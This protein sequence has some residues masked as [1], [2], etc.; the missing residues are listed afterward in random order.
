MTDT[1]EALAELDAP[2]A[3]AGQAQRLPSPKLKAPT[4]RPAHAGHPDRYP[5]RQVTALSGGK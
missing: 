2:I 4:E 3:P 1:V 5:N